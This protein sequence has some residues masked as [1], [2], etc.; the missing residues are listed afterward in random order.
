V[1]ADQ[2]WSDKIDEKSSFGTVSVTLKSKE[3]KEKTEI[4]T[5]LVEKADGSSIEVKHLKYTGWA[6]FETPDDIEQFYR[7]FALY[8]GFRDQCAPGLPM[9]IHCSAG[10]GRS[11]TFI[12][13]DLMLD[14]IEYQLVQEKMDS[15]LLNIPKL[16]SELRNGRPGMIQNKVN[17]K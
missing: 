12:A 5:F 9:T 17:Q 16:V 6:D 8:R 3:D 1:K 11:G 14:H 2:Y 10:V 15:F 13:M 7:F 4:R